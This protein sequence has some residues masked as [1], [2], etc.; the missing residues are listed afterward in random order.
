MPRA[1]TKTEVTTL[2]MTPEV[3]GLWGKCA[4]HEQRTLANMFEVMLRQYAR[5]I[6]VKTDTP[7]PATSPIVAKPAPRIKREAS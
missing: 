2:K 4:A 6:G 1:K 7:E 5:R 3:R